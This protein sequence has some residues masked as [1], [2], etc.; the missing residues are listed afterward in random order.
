[1]LIAIHWVQEPASCLLCSATCTH[2]V[3]LDA[4]E[5][6]IELDVR[7]VDLGGAEDA[8]DPAPV[9]GLCADG[10]ASVDELQRRGVG[11]EAE[12]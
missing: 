3:G 10:F 11:R 6:R 5:G 2:N 1:M 9:L 4:V 12:S 7:L 8:D